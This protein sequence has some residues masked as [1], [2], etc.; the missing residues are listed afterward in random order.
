[1]TSIPS[2]SRVDLIQRRRTLRRQRRLQL[3]QSVWRTLAVFGFL[4]GLGWA[5]NQ[6]IWLL[7]A[8]TQITVEGN[9]LLS[10]KTIQ[11]L[12]PLSY[13]KW[14]LRVHPDVIALSLEAQPPI[15]DATVTRQ[16][17][18]P[19]ITVQVKERVPV[20]IAVTEL[21]N[22]TTRTP[23]A[24]M[25]LLDQSGIWIP[26]QSYGGF[27]RLKLPQLKVIGP[28]EQYRP[29]W[30]QL[31]QLVSH[32]SI[33]VI[34]IDCRD[35]ANLIL[36]TEIGT[37]HLGPYSPRLTQQLQKLSEMR[38][39][40]AKIKSSQVAYIDLKNPEF[41]L[42]QMNQNQESVKPDMP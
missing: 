39:L 9:H 13:P 36:K 40:P 34:E 37:V 17:F 42:V 4:G 2:V 5:A 29:Y 31:Y 22:A 23:T 32:S 7:R 21:T 19:G 28:I 30:V 3:F 15:A 11:S 8:P 33:R 38:Q 20:A 1:M 35:P 26:I 27:S 41:P 14:L 12:I 18:P 24:S 10:T 6:P 16:L 25:G